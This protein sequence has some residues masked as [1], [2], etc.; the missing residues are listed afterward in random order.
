MLIEHK[1]QLILWQ[2][3]YFMNLILFL[4]TVSQKGVTSTEAVLCVHTVL[5]QIPSALQS[6]CNPTLKLASSY[7][8][9]RM[10]FSSSLASLCCFPCFC[11]S[12]YPYIFI[13]S[14]DCVLPSFFAHFL[15]PIPSCDLL[16]RPHGL[17]QLWNTTVSFLMTFTLRPRSVRKIQLPFL[18]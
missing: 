13:H 11:A 16:P 4:I 12:L 15:L 1:C 3:L 14:L 9:C 7:H 8:L 5:P 10:F 18:N 2:G 17:S 6:S